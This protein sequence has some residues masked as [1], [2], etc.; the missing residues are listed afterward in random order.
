MLCQSCG[1]KEAV[2]HFTK[3][4]NGKME[5]S[6]LCESCA[7]KE[8]D[9]GFNLPFS[10]NDLFSGL[11]D[12][13]ST[14]SKEEVKCPVCNMSYRNIMKTGKFGCA[15]CYITFE[16][17]L[18]PLFKSIHGHDKHTGKIPSNSSIRI[19]KQREIEKMK[20]KLD[21]AI[22]EERFEDAAVFRDKIKA[23]EEE[24][25]NSDDREDLNS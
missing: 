24:I 1:E 22:L 16:R 5:E 23:L 4:V 8:N 3:I 2:I 15:N 20:M 19:K 7:K 14:S 9:W 12:F 21:T 11:V 17:E 6:H 10:V 13:N 18:S 25:S